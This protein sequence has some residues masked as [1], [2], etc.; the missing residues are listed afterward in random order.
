VNGEVIDPSSPGSLMI[1]SAP[2]GTMNFGSRTAIQSEASI[3]APALIQF[4]GRLYIA[5]T[6]FDNQLNLM[7]SSDGVTWNE[8]TLVHL[9]RFSLWNPTLAVFDGKLYV[10]FADLNSADGGVITLISS[11]DGRNFTS[12]AVVLPGGPAT[13]RAPALTVF[14]GKLFV[15]WASEPGKLALVSSSDGAHFDST[16]QT[17]GVPF[18][19]RVAATVASGKLMIACQNPGTNSIGILTSVDGITTQGPLFVEGPDGPNAAPALSPPSLSFSQPFVAW[20]HVTNNQSGP[21][22]WTHINP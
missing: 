2:V 5:W 22:V 16:V 3:E 9:G 20:I 8:S 15:V 18:C 6:G 11:F 14:A 13:S 4:D 17:G 19:L 7:S 12:P 1:A 10:G 21:I